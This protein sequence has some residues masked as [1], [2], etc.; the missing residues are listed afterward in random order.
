M[1]ALIMWSVVYGLS[2]LAEVMGICQQSIAFVGIFSLGYVVYGL[3][4]YFLGETILNATCDPMGYELSQNGTEVIIRLT[5]ITFV[6]FIASLV[7]KAPFATIFQFVT[8]GA[9]VNNE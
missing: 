9:S 8:L 4:L 5:F 1:K 7:F 6:A 2:I 3:F